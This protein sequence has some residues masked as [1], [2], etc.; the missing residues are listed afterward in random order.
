VNLGEQENLVI[1]MI[2]GAVEFEHAITR[3][4]KKAKQDFRRE[5]GS[6]I[7]GFGQLV[8]KAERIVNPGNEDIE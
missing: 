5:M 8:S 6:V 7:Y 4:G 1:P 2:H 3:A